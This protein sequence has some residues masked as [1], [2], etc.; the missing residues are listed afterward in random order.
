MEQKIPE[1]G[2]R[3]VFEENYAVNVFGAAVTADIFLPL[4]KKST[5]GPRLL[6]ISSGLGSITTMSDPNG[7]YKHAQ[8]MVSISHE[9]V[10]SVKLSY[11]RPR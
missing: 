6:N 7:A 8:Y 9:N 10:F 1:I 5:V 2:L 4:L 11:S 3:K